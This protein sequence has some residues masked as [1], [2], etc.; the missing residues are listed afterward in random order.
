MRTLTLAALA[1]LA[2]GGCHRHSHDDPASTWYVTYGNGHPLAATPDDGFIV[3]QE[4]D[5]AARINNHRVS[6]GVP[7]LIDQGILRDAAR[8]HSIHMAMHGFTGD[9]N[10]EGDSP[11]DRLD[12]LGVA[13][14]SV[15]ENVVYDW[16][17]AFDVYW[18]MINDPG[19]HANID[20]PNFWYFG[21]GYEHDAGSFWND[22]WTV[23]F[24]E[25]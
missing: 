18:E 5:L 10:P 16:D 17:D 8:A 14:S 24:R 21:V 15:G 13:F 3:D 19:M 4:N 1:A 22:Y 9:I 2:V 7:A 11:A 6:I 12:A 20:D 23:K 25:P